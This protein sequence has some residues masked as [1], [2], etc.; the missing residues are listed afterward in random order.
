MF[1]KIHLLLVFALLVSACSSSGAQSETSDPQGPSDSTDESSDESSN[2]LTVA[3]TFAPTAGLAIDTDDAITL[4]DSGSTEGLVSS[5]PDGEPEPALAESWTQIDETT[6]EF[7]LRPDVSFHDGT[8]FTADAVVTAFEFLANSATPPRT[9]KGI[10]LAAEA[11]DDQTVKVVTENPDPILPLRLS[12]PNTGI[13]SPAAYESEVPDPIGFGTGPFEI[14]DFKPEESL[15]VE[16]FDDYWGETANLDGATMQFLPEASTRAAAIRAG[17]VD[18]AEGIALADL[19]AIEED[20]TISLEKFSL[21]RTT[22][23]YTNTANGALSNPEVRKAMALAVDQQSIADELLEGEF[24]PASGYFG[25]EN[26]WAPKL[27][28]EY[29]PD[30]AK[31]V[32][33]EAGFST[34]GSDEGLSVNLWTYP[35]RPELEDIAVALQAQLEQVG[36]SVELTVAEYTPLETDVLAGKHDLFLVSRSYYLDIADAGAFLTSDFT[37]EGGYNLNAYC[38]EDFDAIIADLAE[39]TELSEREPLFTAAAELLAEENVG[40]TVAHNQASIAV[41]DRVDG[42]VPDPFERTLITSSISVS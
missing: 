22:S 11:I 24:A 9:I 16:R 1:K 17:D 6:W 33:E 34:D 38:S 30:E 32:L 12:S 8:P 31:K 25:S 19:E 39:T 28:I 13:L 5:G 3:V 27:D 23:I 20:E 37:C 40:I 4:S 21:P 15:T 42:F 18:I 36:F 41:S 10:G 7:A 29:S 2:T 35:D 26:E 14:V